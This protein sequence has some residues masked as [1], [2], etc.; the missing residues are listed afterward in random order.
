MQNLPWRGQKIAFTVKAEGEGVRDVKR[1]EKSTVGRG[2][3]IKI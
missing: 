1:R 3:S 2:T